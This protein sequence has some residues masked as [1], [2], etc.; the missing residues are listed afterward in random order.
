MKILA[1]DAAT[2]YAT[3]AVTDGSVRFLKTWRSGGRFTDTLA[4]SVVEAL[5]AVG[6]VE[7]IDG[8]AVG[9]GPGSYTGIR[10]AMALAK[11]VCLASGKPLVGVSTLESLAFGCGG[12]EG[13]ICAAVGAGS[14]RLAIGV[15]EGPWSSWRR[16]VPERSESI[17]MA[18]KSVVPGSLVCGE[19]ADLL[20]ERPDIVRAP[21]SFD[22]PSAGNVAFLGELYFRAGGT[23]QVM[24][25]APNYLRL[26]SPEERLVATEAAS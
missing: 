26:S 23:D 8:V 25:V 7:A 6:G 20:A 10:V 21:K 15:F 3:I 5:N 22:A 2:S 1:V 24:T 11:G 18:R 4:L 9:V 13:T 12:W 17:D 16:S 14:G 19:A